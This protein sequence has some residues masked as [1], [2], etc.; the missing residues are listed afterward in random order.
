V[1]SGVPRLN[2]EPIAALLHR[3]GFIAA[4][5]LEWRERTPES[6]ENAAHV[7]HDGMTPLEPE[8]SFVDPLGSRRIT[9]TPIIPL[10]GT[11]ELLQDLPSVTRDG[12]LRQIDEVERWSIQYMDK[13][14]SPLDSDTRPGSEP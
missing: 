8:R 9:Y 7:M 1:D 10:A 3:H 11:L 4:A 2:L 5:T 6:P 14:F 12:A 13:V